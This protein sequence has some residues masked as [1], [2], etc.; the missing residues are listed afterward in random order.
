MYMYIQKKL[1][2]LAVRESTPPPHWKILLRIIFSIWHA[3]LGYLNGSPVLAGGRTSRG[4]ISAIH[5]IEKVQIF[6]TSMFLISRFLVHLQAL[7]QRTSFFHRIFYGTMYT[8][9]R[10]HYTGF[11]FK[12]QPFICEL[13]LFL[14]F[15]DNPIGGE[16]KNYRIYNIK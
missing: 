11:F 15:I 3:Q 9:T 2:L 5:R 10:E 13:I 12:D 4:R 8:I 16:E 1:S 14:F 6:Y 7:L